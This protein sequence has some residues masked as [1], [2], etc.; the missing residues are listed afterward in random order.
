MII[1]D[2]NVISELMKPEP[3]EIVLDWIRGQEQKNLAVSVITLA[4]ISYGLERLPQG[5]RRADLQGRFERLV[6]QGF[7]D[8]VFQFESKSALL[9]GELCHIRL[10]QGLHLDAFDML[11]AAIALVNDCAIATRNTS[12]FQGC[13]LQLLNPFSV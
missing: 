6:D 1:L 3:Y 5:K 9:Y 10:S 8:R 2:T 13:S 11:I 4:E 7:H 12:D